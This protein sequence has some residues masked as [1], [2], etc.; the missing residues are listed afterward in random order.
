[1]AS[2]QSPDPAPRLEPRRVYSGSNITPTSAA[3]PRAS[4]V[5]LL[6]SQGYL[7]NCAL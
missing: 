1:M 7:R 5:L 3:E 2:D 6:R 4:V